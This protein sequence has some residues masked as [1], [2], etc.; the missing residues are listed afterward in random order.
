MSDDSWQ[1]DVAKMT[2]ILQIIVGALVA[3]ALFFLVIALV[4]GHRG[5]ARRAAADL[6]YPCRR[7]VYRHDAYCA[8]GLRLA[9]HRRGRR[10]IAGGTYR[11]AVPQQW[12]GAA[13]GPIGDAQ[14]LFMVFQTRTIAGAAMFEGCAF[15][16]TICYLIE[17]RPAS[18]VLAVCLILGVAAHFPTPARAIGWIER[19]LDLLEQERRPP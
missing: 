6:A 7:P 10:Q 2:R 19:Q 15:F 8:G 12:S 13:G 18:L 3:G 16:A 9:D 14:C 4:I 17:G 1:A 5:A 11:P